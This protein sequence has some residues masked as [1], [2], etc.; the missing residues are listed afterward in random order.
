MKIKL[1]IVTEVSYQK[2]QFDDV[3]IFF[4]NDTDGNTWRFADNSWFSRPN[5]RWF[6]VSFHFT[7]HCDFLAISTRRNSRLFNKCW[8]SARWLWL[9]FD[10]QIQFGIRFSMRILDMALVRSTI[11]S[12]WVLNWQEISWTLENRKDINVAV[13]SIPYLD[14][15][16]KFIRIAVQRSSF[17]FN[18]R[19]LADLCWF[20]EPSHRWSGLRF[21]L[22]FHRY[23]CT[24]FIGNNLW[25]FNEGR[26][27]SVRRFF[28]AAYE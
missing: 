25:F 4:L 11:H 19:R 17:H 16:D 24:I 27:T 20:F 2:F 28:F 13:N 6:G 8:S 23:K 12:R 3:S 15:E 1:Q 14:F 22:A 9:C 10:V 18:S 5:N 26:T 21:T 7:C